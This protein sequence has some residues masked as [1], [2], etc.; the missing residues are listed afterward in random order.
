M[1]GDIYTVAEES[2]RDLFGLSYLLAKLAGSDDMEKDELHM[3][4]LLSDTVYKIAGDLN[5]AV[6]NRD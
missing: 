1:K 4:G 2:A 5:E 3:F 6:I